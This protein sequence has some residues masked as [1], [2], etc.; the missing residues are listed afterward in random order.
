MIAHDCKD[1]EQNLSHFNA[2]ILC[3]QF[4]VFIFL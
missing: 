3:E 1:K 2:V 4:R